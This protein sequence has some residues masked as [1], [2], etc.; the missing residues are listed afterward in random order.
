MERS[1]T[2]TGQPHDHSPGLPW[3]LWLLPDVIVV[4]PL[5]AAL[6]GGAAAVVLLRDH[7]FVAGLLALLAW[8]AYLAF[9]VRFLSR[10]QYTSFG[11]ALTVALIGVAIAAG[12]FAFA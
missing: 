8:L 1:A 7:R 4:T 9:G 5:I 11:F 12:F 2:I 3:W 6:F 10:R